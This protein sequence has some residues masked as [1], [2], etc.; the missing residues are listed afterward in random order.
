[1]KMESLAISNYRVF[2]HALVKEIPNMAV[3][4]GENGSGKSTFFDVFGFLHDCLNAGVRKALMKRGGFEEVVSRQSKGPI[5]FILKFR[6]SED[7]PLITYEL[8]IGFNGR[9]PV[10]EREVLRLRRGS[11]GAPWKVLEFSNGSGMA[12]QGEIN[13]YE[14]VRNASTRSEQR[15]TS[16]DILAVDS[17]GQLQEFE[18]VSALRKLID[19]W[20]VSDFRIDVARERQ[21]VSDGPSLSRSGDN[22]SA[23]AMQLMDEHPKAFET[24]LDKMR[25]RIPGVESVEPVVTQDGYFLLRFGS[26]SF[27][28]PFSARY[29][30]D[31]TIKMFAYLMLLADPNP[32]ALLCVEEPENQLYPQ[33]LA[34]LAEEFRGYAEKGG[35]VFI[36]THSPDFLNAVEL[37]ELFC[38]V[39]ANG[40]SEILRAKDMPLVSSLYRG[41]DKLGWLWN[42]RILPQKTDES[43]R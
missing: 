38:I 36:S 39:K 3:F 2:K 5:E 8:A 24:V 13:T 22:L 7:E 1:M 35:Q 11:K 10:V 25:N 19:D 14:D 18:A 16:P 27:V 4:L 40:Y 9:T 6:P 20:Y 21:D 12:V 37:D 26:D 23:V 15:L 42:Q 31:G 29:V 30:S 33:L 28:D 32:H 43:D 41:G 17:L 34:I